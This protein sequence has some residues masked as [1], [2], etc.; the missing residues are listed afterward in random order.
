MQKR[1]T[2]VDVMSEDAEMEK[3][4]CETQILS[5]LRGTPSGQARAVK[6]HRFAHNLNI[7]SVGCTSTVMDNLNKCWNHHLSFS[8]TFNLPNLTGQN[9]SRWLSWQ[10]STRQIDHNNIIIVGPLQVTGELQA[11]QWVVGT[12]CER[13][14]LRVRRMA[15]WHLLCVN[16]KLILLSSLLCE[17]TLGSVDEDNG[18]FMH[19]VDVNCMPAGRVMS[20]L[21]AS[22]PW[23]D[24]YS[25]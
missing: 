23:V 18:E 25:I 12:N 16:E 3:K 24:V 15:P 1:Q 5:L 2:W 7:F 13:A 20:S 9:R 22:S 6:V 4:Q 10:L 17:G 8:W 21:T 14:F 11:R 19:G